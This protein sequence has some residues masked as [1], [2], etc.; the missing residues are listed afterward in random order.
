MLCSGFVMYKF[1]DS[2]SKF[3]R[4][5]VVLRGIREDEISAR[6]SGIHTTRYKL[7]I[8]AMSG[9][10][11]GIAG[12]VYAHLTGV[13]GASNLELFFSIL[14]IIWCVF[15][16]LGTIYGAV[17]GVYILYPALQFIRVYPLGE[18]L[19]GVIL[20]VML[21]LILLF[22]PEGITVWI[23]DKIEI[24]CPRCKLVNVI[25]RKKCRGC[26]APLHLQKEDL[27]AG[28]GAD[29]AQIPDG[30]RLVAVWWD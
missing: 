5:G 18:E 17:A 13:A 23:R 9:F 30:F 11:S 29:V 19:Q 14:V 10:F 27:A 4:V 16:G 7:G 22:M 28:E 15:G 3:V 24:E 2:Q 12:A 25:T 20:A 26:W 6:V 21:S 8:F 1:S